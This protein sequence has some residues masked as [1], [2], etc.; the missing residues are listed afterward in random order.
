MVQSLMNRVGKRDDVEI[1]KKPFIN[2]I[3]VLINIKLSWLKAVMPI[4]LVVT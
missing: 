4:C 3:I 1:Y 2:A